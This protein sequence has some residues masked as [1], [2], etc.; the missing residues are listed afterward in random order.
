MHVSPI[1]FEK[2]FS[3]FKSLIREH[4]GGREFT[5]FHEGLAA[6]W[7]AYKEHVRTEALHRL[8]MPTWKSTDIGTGKILTRVIQAIEINEP[9]DFR[10]K[11]EA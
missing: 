6:E 4:S 1:A 8:Q 9:R 10:N 7:E 2:Q 5:T 11:M 3:R